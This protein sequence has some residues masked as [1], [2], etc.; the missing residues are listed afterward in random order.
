MLI[1][2]LHLDVLSPDTWYL[3]P[4]NWHAIT[5][6]LTYAIT[7]YWNTWPAVVQLTEYYYTWHLYYITYSWLSLLR[8]LDMIIILLPDIWY[9]STSV[10]LYSCISCTHVPTLLLFLIARSYRRPAEHT[11]WYRNDEDVS[12]D[13]ATARQILNGTKCHTD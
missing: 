6:Y 5:W 1:I 4:H 11:A 3:T 13:H 2:W 7:W 12:Y 10:L 9:S 8:G